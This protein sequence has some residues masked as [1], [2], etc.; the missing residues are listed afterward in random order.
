M[1]ELQPQQLIPTSNATESDIMDIIKKNIATEY[2]ASCSCPMLPLSQGG[3]VDPELLVYG[4]QNLR[5]VDAS[6]MPM[7]P[8]GHL[9][10]IVYGIAEKVR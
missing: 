7:I 5:I 8:A 10:A 9:Q 1:R 6:I 4:T 2:H 3:V